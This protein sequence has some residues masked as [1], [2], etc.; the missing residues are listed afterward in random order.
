MTNVITWT[1]VDKAVREMLDKR[2]MLQTGNSDAEVAYEFINFLTRQESKLN[3]T[4]RA[5]TELLESTR[6]QLKAAQDQPLSKT[7]RRLHNLEA[8][9]TELY[10]HLGLGR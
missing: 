5:R 6:R 4:I 9:V 2:G 7:K 10:D 1:H 8:Q 3:E